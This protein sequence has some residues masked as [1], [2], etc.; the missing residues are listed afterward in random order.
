MEK[1][2]TAYHRLL[3]FKQLKQPKQPKQ[4]KRFIQAVL[5][6]L[7]VLGDDNDQEISPH[8]SRVDRGRNSWTSVKKG[9][10]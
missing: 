5:Q 10:A 8:G 2:A 4:S 3:D 9:V 1:L 6:R 7:F